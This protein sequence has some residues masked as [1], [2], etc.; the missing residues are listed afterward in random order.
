MGGERKGAGH[1]KGSTNLEGSWLLVRLA[2]IQMWAPEAGWGGT[3][4]TLKATGWVPLGE[5]GNLLLGWNVRY[6]V[7]AC[8]RNVLMRCLWWVFVPFAILREMPIH[9][10][11]TL[12]SA[13]DLY[14]GLKALD[15]VL[16]LM[17]LPETGLESAL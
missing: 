17:P 6:P 15:F 2:G 13:T 7:A 4:E 3:W 14:S 8:R 11:G 5:L 12:A 16:F 1:Q 9:F 10:Y